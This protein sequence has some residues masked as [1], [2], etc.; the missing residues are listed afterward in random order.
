MKEPFVGCCHNLRWVWFHFT[1]CFEA[2]MCEIL[3]RI[4]RPL[5][6]NATGVKNGPEP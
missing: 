2:S 1:G 3:D 6:L 4:V 5:A